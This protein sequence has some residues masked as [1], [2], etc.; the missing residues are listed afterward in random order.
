MSTNYGIRTA[1]FLDRRLKHGS[2]VAKYLD[3]HGVNTVDANTVRI[4]NID[5][6][7]DNLTAYNEAS[8]TGGM[9]PSLV[10]FGK[11]EWSI[12]YNYASFLR[13]QDTQLQDIPV[14]SA[15]SDVAKAW[16]DE[17]FV[18]DFDEYALAKVIAARPGANIATWDGTTIDTGVNGLLQKFYNTVTIVTNNGGDTGQAIAWVPSSFADKLRAYITT[19][20]GSDKG[21]TAGVNGLIGKLKGVMIVET[22]DEYF[23]AYPTVKAVIADKRAIAA[24]TQKM[25]PKNGGRKF[26]KDVPGFGG[27]ELQLRARGGV[28]V[29]DRKKYTIATLQ[30]SSS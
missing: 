28:F 17:K 21:Y 13:I 1:T 23:D 11:Q 14:G 8:T 2:T 12:D 9:T 30:T 5:I 24:P 16:V 7:S 27:S 10:E 19:F 20:D 25:T 3:A 22:V 15:V 18:P 6:D 29:F 26:I 4:L